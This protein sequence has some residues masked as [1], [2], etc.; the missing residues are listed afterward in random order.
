[1]RID[2]AQIEQI[3]AEVVRNIQSGTVPAPP[4]PSAPLT[5]PSAGADMSRLSGAFETVDDNRPHRIA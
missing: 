4:T 1:M 2:Q 5:A 3:V